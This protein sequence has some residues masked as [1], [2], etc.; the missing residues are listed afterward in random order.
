MP[1][2]NSRIV[3]AQKSIIYTRNKHHYDWIS[4]YTSVLL[5]RGKQYLTPPL[6][7]FFYIF[8]CVFSM[9]DMSIPRHDPPAEN[10]SNLETTFTIHIFTALL[11]A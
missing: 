2:D 6:G 11:T 5:F 7:V 9:W 1:L 10:W 4:L 8:E 3:H